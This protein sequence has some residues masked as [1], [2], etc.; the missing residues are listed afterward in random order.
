MPDE[1]IKRDRSMKL[2]FLISMLLL[3]T[4]AAPTFSQ[5]DETE[6]VTYFQ[7]E[8]YDDSLFIRIQEEIFIDPP[9]PKA[10]IIVDLRDPA[11][12]TVAIKGALYPFLSF[13]PET[14]AKIQTYPF[15]L[16][17]IDD[18]HFGSVFSDVIEKI[19]FNKIVEPPR[20]GQ[21]VS[22]LHY[23]NPYLQIAGGER[24]GIPFKED[25]GFSLGLGTPYSSPRETNF[26]E[27]NFNILGFY[28]GGF[29][30]LN[31]M[32]AP[33]QFK[34]SVYAATGFQVGYVLPLGNFFE[35]SYQKVVDDIDDEEL[36]FLK[37][38]SD[39]TAL[40]MSGSYLNWEFRY[41]FRTLGATRA[42]FYVA[43]YLGELHI[44]LK[45]RELSVA[46]STF[47]LSF[48]ALVR[49]PIRKKQYAIDILVQRIASSWGFSAFALG[50]SVTFGY[51]PDDKFEITA[52]F[53][54]AR[55]KIGT[56]L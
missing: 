26:A 56:S 21:I 7:M 12:Q 1:T 11:N 41:P 33:R 14:R 50:P 3:C 36:L 16:N 22:T 34:N 48:D 13:S 42:K 2:Y 18:I 15:K 24:F 10:E 44:G 55:L 29:H 39:S 28:V 51:T 6:P 47:D 45:G 40:A 30:H 49:T 52:I 35:V 25:L 23:I 54:N 4:Y 17:L 31:D 20:K 38:N 27:G 9:D 32:Y 37:I 19:K 8:P 53:V 5:E 43:R 46:G